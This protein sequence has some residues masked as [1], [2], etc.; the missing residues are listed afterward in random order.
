[1]LKTRRLFMWI[2]VRPC[3]QVVLLLA[4]KEELECLLSRWEIIILR[5]IFLP[6]NAKET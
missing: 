4:A 6:L 3:L 1:M 5:E 2:S